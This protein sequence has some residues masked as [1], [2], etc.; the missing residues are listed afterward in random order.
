MEGYK[1]NIE[2]IYS[3]LQNILNFSTTNNE[4]SIEQQDQIIPTTPSTLPDVPTSISNNDSMQDEEQIEQESQISENL[5]Y[6][7]TLQD[8]QKA[9]INAIDDIYGET[10]N[11][12]VL[13]SRHIRTSITNINN[14]IQQE[15]NNILQDTPE[16]QKTEPKTRPLL[17][18]FCTSITRYT[19]SII[20]S[21]LQYEQSVLNPN[22][23]KPTITNRLRKKTKSNN[24]DNDNEMIKNRNIF[25]IN[26]VQSD[27]L[28]TLQVPKS[29][30]SHSN[31]PNNNNNNNNKR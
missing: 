23:E 25:H 10:N 21:L 12:T 5:A 11:I 26:D 7:R 17:E 16:L 13:Q 2:L 1:E 15:I 3:F 4:L 22:Y 20:N 14:V 18:G 29:I 19:Q 27:I 9:T 8:A 28:K 30:I 24:K 31:S 6:A